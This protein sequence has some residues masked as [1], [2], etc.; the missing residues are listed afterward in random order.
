[1]LAL[2]RQADSADGTGPA[3]ISGEGG[4][5]RQR[6]VCVDLECDRRKKC[7]APILHERGS[8]GGAVAHG[9]G[10]TTREAKRE[11]YANGWVRRDEKDFC[12]YC[13]ADRKG[14]VLQEPLRE[15]PIRLL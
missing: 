12:P 13:E 1:V 2:C 14:L 3:A 8:H 11:A 9:V 4:M 15:P 5:M 10:S 7:K 6:Y